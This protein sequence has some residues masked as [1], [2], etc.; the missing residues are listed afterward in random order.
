MSWP[1]KVIHGAGDKP[2]IVVTYKG[3]E[4]RFLAEEISLMVL[5]KMEDISEAY[6]GSPVTDAIVTVPAYFNESQRLATKEAGTITGLNVL[7][8]INDPTAAT[9]AYGLDNWGTSSVAK[10]VLIFYF[11]GGTFSVT[12][13]TI[14]ADAIEVGETHF[15]GW[16]KLVK[17]I[18]KKLKKKRVR[19]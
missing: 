12:L 4:K 10:N 9:I 19:K 8:I 18:M 5:T 3:H 1:F 6:L 7:T 11:G 15:G 2:M 16:D 17:H 14:N 13:T